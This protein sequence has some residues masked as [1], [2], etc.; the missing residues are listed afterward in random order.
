LRIDAPSS[1]GIQSSG[2]SN[3]VFSALTI[4]NVNGVGAD[5]WNAVNLGG[6]NRIDNDSLFQTFGALAG[7]AIDVVNNNTGMTSLTIDSSTFQNQDANNGATF[8]F[9]EGRG[10][11]NM[12]TVAVTNNLFTNLSGNALS[13]SII[14]TGTMTSL[15]NN[16]VFRAANPGGLGGISGL[17]A[18]ASGN[19]VHTIT[20]DNN[21]FDDVQLAGGNAGTLAVA[22]FNTSS[23]SAIISNNEFKDLDGD[24]NVI[25][26]AQAIRVVSEQ[27]GGGAVDVT[28]SGNIVNDVGRHAI[29]VSAR[30]QTPD[31]DVLIINNTIGNLAPV[32]F[33]NRDAI[34]I[35][36]E[37]DAN[38]D[39]ALQGNSVTANVS[40]QEI[41]NVVT[42]R[43]M[44][45]NT[46]VLNVTIG[47][48]A[49]NSFTNSNGGGADNVVIET[50]DTGET[51]C[52]NMANNTLTGV[53]T[54]DLFNSGGTFNVTQASAA[55]LAAVNGGV[56]VSAPDSYNFGQPACQ[57]PTITLVSNLLVE[58]DEAPAAIGDNSMGGVQFEATNGNSEIV[59]GN[60][61]TA[62]N[63]AS[64]VGGQ[65]SASEANVSVDKFVPYQLT[66]QLDR[67]SLLS[68]GRLLNS[69][70]TINIPIGTLPAGKSV[71]VVFD[72]TVDNTIP[73][74]DTQVC[75]QA[76]IQSNE[77]PDVL[78]DDP[79]TGAVDDPT[80]TAVPQ[81]DL[82]IT[83]ADGPD[84]VLPGS[85]LVYTITVT[86][87]G[88]SDAQNVVVT[89]NLP[90]G[91]TFVSTSGCAE[92]PNG[93]PTCSLGTIA[94]TN[95]AQV[96][97]Q[98]TVDIGTSG[99][100][101]NT[102]TVSSSTYDANGGNN[103]AIA[104]TTVLEID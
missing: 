96:I 77:L 44:A 89:D 101:T 90:G 5:G 100:I 98:T 4:Q 56:T 47:T 99:I 80:C 49:G 29:F 27:T 21:D 52:L 46:P 25:L 73:A 95:S 70:E 43:I 81:A 66:A 72:A 36:S 63:R 58:P 86:N 75:N 65:I 9:I 82:S 79:D 102:A 3:L 50:L 87:N 57:T 97:I 35:L 67:S 7:G 45:G 53:T 14:D 64:S 76:I 39:V 6:V 71:T 62:P 24:G 92:D 69:G 83:K 12:G 41:L 74:N 38:L 15:L 26:D 2:G 33:T 18:T 22:F 61:P 93:V 19:G 37:D 68:N 16:N 104:E 91:V 31:L 40:S 20:I 13:T 17:S 48:T 94:A 23:G 54:L 103:S 30:N 84:P 1:Y 32:G 51:I 8:I 59:V 88:P 85:T 28:I 10:T 42:D 78:S 34:E 55:A 11:S 60:V